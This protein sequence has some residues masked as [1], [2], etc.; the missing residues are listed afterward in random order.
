MHALG[1]ALL[2]CS[3]AFAIQAA[4]LPA[5]AFFEKHCTECHDA[6]TKKGNLDLTSLKPDFADAESFA[7]WVKVHDRIESGEMP[8]KKKPRPA[9]KETTAMTKWLR[10]SLVGAEQRKLAGEGRTG[11]RRLTRPEY[12][13]T[14]RDLFDMPGLALAGDLPPDGSAHGFDNN[15]DA[16]DISHVNLA[17]YVEAADKALDL[18]IAT[19]PQA[20]TLRRERLSLVQP[21]GFVAHVVMNGDGVLLRDRKPDPEFPPAGDAGSHLDEGA[22]ERMGSFARGSTVG[23]FRHEDESLSP[24]FAAHVTIY[25]GMYRVRTSLWSF[26]WDKGAVLPAR[27]TEAARLSVVQL[28][29]D[30]RGG[31]H[32]S[33]VLG[34]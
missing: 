4:D 13:N 26:Q 27:G 34:Y 18:A 31:Q 15:S 23:L 14:M 29:G 33:Y 21:G 1:S 17:K 32:P 11:L 5:R 2:F 22:H 12:E 30:G 24:Y 20:P 19:Q 10:T 8:P 7:R 9:V 28:T 25:P 16:L 6:G 3:F